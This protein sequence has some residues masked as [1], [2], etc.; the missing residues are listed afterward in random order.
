MQFEKQDQGLQHIVRFVEWFQEP[1]RD[2]WLVFRDEGVSLHALMYDHVALGAEDD[3]GDSKLL[4]LGHN[5]Q[6]MCWLRV[7]AV[8]RPVTIVCAACAVLDCACLDL[9]VT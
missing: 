7:A 6:S 8:S 2:L 9:I 4:Y 3:A 5:H 1:G